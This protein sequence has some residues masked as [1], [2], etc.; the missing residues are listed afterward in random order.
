MTTDMMIGTTVSVLPY[1]SPLET[2]RVFANVDQ[3]SRGR[4]ILGVGAGWAAEEFRIL[5][6]P[7]DKR[8]AMTTEYLRAIK[9]LWT[10][11]IASFDGE[12][13]SFENVHTTPRPCQAPHPAIWVGGNSAPS[14]RRAIEHGTAWHPI[15]P[16][17][18]DFVATMLP[19]FVEMAERLE[20]PV[21]EVCPRIRLRVTDSL[22]P[23]AERLAGEGTVEQIRGDLAV[24]EELGCSWVLLDTYHDYLV[25]ELVDSEW[26]WDMF[27]EIANDA[28]DLA[29]GSV[30]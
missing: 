24:F 16:T 3:L 8:G 30:R 4:C 1:R 10:D 5:G 12:F 14:M 17:I 22:R 9:A 26:Q 13:V 15:R 20:L 28:F 6:V 11:D 7:F 19:T 27:E 29:R 23:D 21:P 18:P 25:D 2:A